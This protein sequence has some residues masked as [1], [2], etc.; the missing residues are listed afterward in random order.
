MNTPPHKSQLPYFGLT[1]EEVQTSREKFGNN[2]M[3]PPQR[4]PWWKQLFEKF[5]DPVIRILMMAAIAA[6]ATSEWIEGGGILV[7]VLLATFI[8]FLNEFK[9]EKEFDILNT[10]NDE[11]PFKVIRSGKFELLPKKDIVVGDIIFLELGEEAPADADVL[12]AVNLQV[13]QSKLTGESLP[14]RKKPQSEINPKDEK[15]VTYPSHKVYRGTPIVEGHAYLRVDAVGGATELGKT[16]VAAGETV[17]DPTPL[18]MQLHKLGKLIA[19]LGFSISGITFFALILRAVL[20]T[21]EIQ[22]TYVQWCICAIL[23]IAVLVLLSKI[24]VPI[25]ADGFA[26][27]IPK[28]HRSRIFNGSRLLGWGLLFGTALLIIGGGLGILYITGK[29]PNDL[30]QWINPDILPRILSFFMI[31]VVLIVVAVPEGLAMS[32][33]LSLAYSM[34]KM[35]ASNNLVRKMHACETIGAATVICTDKTGTLTMNQ[36]RVSELF[37]HAPSPQ[38]V[39]VALAANSTANLLMKNDTVEPVG[40]P[41]EGALILWIHLQHI[42]V[43]ELRNAFQLEKQWTFSTE[44]KFMATRGRHPI[45]E[46][47]TVLFAKGAPEILLNRCSTFRDE[48]GVHPLDPHAKTQIL[49]EIKTYQL[50]G[51]RTL[52]FAEGTDIIPGEEILEIANNMQWCGFAAISDPVREDVPDAIA[53]CRDAGIQVKMVTGDTPDTAKEIGR[54]IHLWDETTTSPYQILTGPEFEALSDEEVKIAAKELKIMARARPH[55]KLRLVKTLKLLG[56]IVAVTGDGTNDAPAMNYADV[57]IAM[58]KTGTAVAKEASDIILLDDSFT[59]IVNAVMWG[60]SLYRNIQ[61]F[62]L[63]QLTVNVVALVIAMI[64][65]YTVIEMPLTVIQM[66]WINLIMDTF[67]ALAL[68]TDPPK[69]EVLKEQPRKNSAFIVTPAMAF[70]IFGTAALFLAVL[71][72][73]LFYMDQQ[74]IYPEDGTIPNYHWQT[75]FFTTLVM[76]QFWNLFNAKCWGSNDSI[77]K[78][79]WDNKTFACIALIIFITQILLVNW[80]GKLFRT[81]PISISN[82][83]VIVG[84]TFF[85][86]GFGEI[87]RFFKRKKSAM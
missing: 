79:L 1:Q 5:N 69:R 73:L 50:R 2:L 80:G 87:Y 76:M 14:V 53:C 35:T 12:E 52:G 33:T 56:E 38:H 68:A 63:F 19:M 65:P 82:W 15:D 43:N 18:N 78:H 48:T 85:I 42:D 83:I 57:G 55:D 20:W 4:V 49:N 70:G 16:A 86:L 8:A 64:G 41:T 60:R 84:G 27:F 45:Y 62:I 11:V 40:N 61:K 29:L 30:T 44:R 10:V 81:E 24:W 37:Y 32:V 26:L 77:F 7:A 22:Q 67:A 72:S 23:F 36:M 75:I 71:I 34:R 66:L 59:S 39:A 58:G 51:M 17:T 46:N 6:M 25:F 3:P 31:A 21:G 54:K 47:Q 74:L 28:I 13:D 9:A